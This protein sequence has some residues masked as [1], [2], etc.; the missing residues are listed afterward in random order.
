METQE[1]PTFFPKNVPFVLLCCLFHSV[2][3]TLCSPLLTH[4][5]Y[6][7]L[8]INHYNMPYQPSLDRQRAALS[9]LRAARYGGIGT[10]RKTWKRPVAELSSNSDVK[11]KHR[12]KKKTPISLQDYLGVQSYRDPFQR[13]QNRRGPSKAPPV[14]GSLLSF[15]VSRAQG[16]SA[17]I[18][19]VHSHL[20][21]VAIRHCTLLYNV[22]T[23]VLPPL[24][25]FYSTS[26]TNRK[27]PSR[28]SH[29]LLDSQLNVAWN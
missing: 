14:T 6:Y 8:C 22:S 1:I 23:S 27:S 17:L 4:S 11:P 12:Q 5:I 20:S 16:G 3:S 13:S 7:K 2:L 15:L 9:E 19:G 26:P 18:P 29:Q 10:H 25:E 28:S 24:P 21:G